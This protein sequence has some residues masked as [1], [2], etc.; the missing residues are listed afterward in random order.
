MSFHRLLL[1][2]F[3][4]YIPLS[5]A[6]CIN[7]ATPSCGVYN[8]CFADRCH[9]D[10]SEFEYFKSYGKKYCEVFLDIP[11][12]SAK[13][14]A[15]RNATLKCLQEKIV[16]ELPSDGQADTCNCKSMQLHA[17]DSHVECYT[18]PNNSICALEPNDWFYI[19]K[20]VDPV[21]NLK[22]QKSRKQMLEVAKI[23]VNSAVE[24]AK[25]PIQ[26]IIQK[27]SN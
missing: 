19:M 24:G 4:L 3:L 5:S 25:A 26:I 6:Q 18:Q 8:S 15:W 20:A 1:C 22:D 11:N 14:K 12:F 7:T 17:Y 21:A 2:V 10:N 16:P 13:G 23:C 27:L 9:C